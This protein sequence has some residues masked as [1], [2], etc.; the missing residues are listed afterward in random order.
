[1]LILCNL[2]P[3]FESSE[4]KWRISCGDTIHLVKEV[5]WSV[6]TWTDF[7]PEFGNQAGHCICAEGT[8]GITKEGMAIV[9]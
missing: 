2:N 5:R 8:L 4:L 1:M 7:F 9:S 6:P 3:E